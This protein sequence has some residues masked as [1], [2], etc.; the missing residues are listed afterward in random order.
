MSRFPK[1]ILVVCI[2]VGLISAAGFGMYLFFRTA[3]TCSDGVHNQREEGV[4]CGPVCG[5]LCSP[6]IQPLQV[7]GA[8]LFP[9]DNDM[10]DMVATITNPNDQFGTGMAAYTLR[11]LDGSGAPL[12]TDLGTFYIAPN[13]TRYI[14]KNNVAI[15]NNP[16]GVT[17]TV[18]EVT[19]QQLDLA[20]NQIDFSV[21][22]GQYAD[23]GKAGA[24]YRASLLNNSDFDFDTVEVD[25]VLLDATGNVVGAS[26]TTLNTLLSKERRDFSVQWPGQLPTTSP[27]VVVSPV[28][29]V[30]ANS[31]FIKQHGSQ[32]RFQQFYPGP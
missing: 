1:Q 18:T 20:F 23:K 6:V 22:G 16:V 15:A 26:L 12:R 10:Y 27:E 4:D 29:N 9:L 25:V 3:P 8:Q 13:Q 32:E 14:I 7:K 31:N 2:F 11:Y 21:L 28:T 19:W 5:N 30:F 17:L 24:L